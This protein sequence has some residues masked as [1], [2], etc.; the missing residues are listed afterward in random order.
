MSVVTSQGSSNWAT[1]QKL[2][3]ELNEVFNFT[4]DLAADTSNHKCKRY[5]DE[6]ANGLKQK[7]VG[8]V[9]YLNPPYKDNYKWVGK[10]ATE[11]ANA[12]QPTTVVC[13]LP[14]RTDTKWAHE[15]V[16]PNSESITFIKGRLKFSNSAVS[17]PFPSMVV[18]FTNEPLSVEQFKVLNSIGYT[19]VLN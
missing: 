12:S 1:P 16:Y 10:A 19:V 2:F 8:E 3:N 18:V 14:A 15:F 13:L 9:A 5:Y 17:A 4:I 7:W 11:V 6:R